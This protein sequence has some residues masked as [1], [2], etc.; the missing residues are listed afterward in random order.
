MEDTLEASYS[1]SASLSAS[2]GDSLQLECH[3]STQTSQHTH[4]SVS[5]ILHADG[6]TNPR[7][8]VSLDRDLTVKPGDGFEERCRSDLIRMDKVE[9]TTFRLKMLEVQ[10][11]DSGNIFCKAVQWIRDPDHLWTQIAH[12]T[13]THCH[14][15]IKAVGKILL[16]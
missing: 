13:T 2:E 4:V 6:E 10:R 3:V 16:L 5:W 14:V 9:D 11:S 15:D 1:G 8:I 12:K 7:P